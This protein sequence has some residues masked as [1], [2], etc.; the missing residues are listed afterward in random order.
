VAVHVLEGRGV[1]TLEG[2]DIPLEPGVFVFMPANAPHALQADE[3]LALLLTL[4][5]A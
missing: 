3:N 4:T 1:L 2:D 5:D